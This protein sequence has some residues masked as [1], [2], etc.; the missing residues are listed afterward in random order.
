MAKEIQDGQKEESRDTPILIKT[1]GEFWNPELVNWDNSWNLLGK[2]RSDFKGPDVNVYEERGVYVLYKDY[3][4]VYVGKA[5][6]Q[7]IGY[8]LQL[9]RQSWRKGPRWDGFSWFGIL[10]LRVND[11]L[12]SRSSA[13]HPR[14]AELIATLEAL[15]IVAIDPRLN[16]RRE[17]FKN[18][19]RLFQSDTDKPAEVK[20]RLD[21]ITNKLDQLLSLP[22]AE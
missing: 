21:L 6:K 8:R 5:D 14:T 11:K 7:S 16:S 15:L 3:Q 20:E 4:P 18:A 10:G 13:F 17:K 22:R 9:H 2:R 19:V 12:R 1:Y